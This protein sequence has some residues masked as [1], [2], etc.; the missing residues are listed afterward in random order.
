M[1][2][3]ELAVE[4]RAAAEEIATA[5]ATAEKAGVAV[6][7]AV[8]ASDDFTSAQAVHVAV[9]AHTT[10]PRSIRVAVDR[11]NADLAEAADR[12]IRVRLTTPRNGLVAVHEMWRAR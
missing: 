8:T 10:P 4:I 5:C 1:S 2:D 12:R 11:L 6:D 3:A 7:L 9:P